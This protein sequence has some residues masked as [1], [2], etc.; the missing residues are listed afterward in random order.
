MVFALAGDSTIT[1]F[2]CIGILIYGAKVVQGERRA[3]RKLKKVYY[4][5]C[6]VSISAQQ[7]SFVFY[8]LVMVKE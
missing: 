1:K 7:I 3:K 6:G 4:L 2:F 8:S 5:S